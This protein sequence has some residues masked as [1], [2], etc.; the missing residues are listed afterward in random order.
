MPASSRRVPI[1]Y[2]AMFKI[3][4]AMTASQRTAVV[5]IGSNVSDDIIIIIFTIFEEVNL[6]DGMLF[7]V[8]NVE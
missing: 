1:L 3:L 8:Q 7:A 5:V 2:P 4:L 6:L